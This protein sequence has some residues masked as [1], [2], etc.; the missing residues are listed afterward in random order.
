MENREKIRE[1]LL[2]LQ[3]RIYSRIKQATNSLLSAPQPEKAKKAIATTPICSYCGKKWPQYIGTYEDISAETVAEIRA[4]IAVCEKNPLQSEN[5]KMK[6]RLERYEP[7]SRSQ[8]RRMSMMAGK[9]PS[10]ILDLEE[11]LGKCRKAIEYLMTQQVPIHFREIIEKILD[12]LDFAE[13]ERKE[14]NV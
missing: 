5:S 1:I 12:P 9:P 2:A 13:I 10:Y 7:H 11:R 3:S 14:K 8:G 6:E 4:H